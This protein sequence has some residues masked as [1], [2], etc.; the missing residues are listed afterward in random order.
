M[1]IA[2]Y[3]MT[4]SFKSKQESDKTYHDYFGELL[5]NLRSN[6]QFSQFYGPLL[7]RYRKQAKT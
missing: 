7:K 4:F 6:S 2:H 1:V 3:Y 5:E